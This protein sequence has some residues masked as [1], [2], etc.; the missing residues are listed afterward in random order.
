MHAQPCCWPDLQA[1][2]AAAASISPDEETAQVGEHTGL[3][4]SDQERGT[5]GSQSPLGWATLIASFT[6]GTQS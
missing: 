6:E 5:P 3:A 1:G 4:F 2:T